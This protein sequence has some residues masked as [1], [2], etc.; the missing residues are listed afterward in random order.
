MDPPPLSQNGQLRFV[1]HRLEAGCQVR[2]RGEGVWKPEVLQGVIKEYQG[3]T[4]W[5]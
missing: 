5:R 3:E 1:I 2:S 4:F